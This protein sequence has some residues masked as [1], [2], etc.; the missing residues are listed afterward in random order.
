MVHDKLTDNWSPK[1]FV[2]KPNRLTPW[3]RTPLALGRWRW[4]PAV[5]LYSLTPSLCYTSLTSL[6]LCYTFPNLCVTPL[7]L[8]VTPVYLTYR[9]LVLFDTALTLC[10]TWQCL[11]VCPVTSSYLSPPPTYLLPPVHLS[12]VTCHL[13]LPTSYL[14]WQMFLLPLHVNCSR[15]KVRTRLYFLYTLSHSPE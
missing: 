10:N 14:Q 13:L 8:C 9:T 11:P 15:D 2:K 3:Q 12:P 4:R 1:I 6:T 5:R 7:T